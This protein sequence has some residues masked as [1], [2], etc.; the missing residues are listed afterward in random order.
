MRAYQL[1]EILPAEQKIVFLASILLLSSL[2]KVVELPLS[3]PICIYFLRFL[4]YFANE[5]EKLHQRHSRPPACA[6]S[7]RQT[8]IKF[9]VS[10]NSL[11]ERKREASRWWSFL[12][13][14]VRGSCCDD[15]DTGAESKVIVL[16]RLF[17]IFVMELKLNIFCRDLREVKTW[18]F[19]HVARYFHIYSLSPTP[20]LHSFFSIFKSSQLFSLLRKLPSCINTIWHMEEM[21]QVWRKA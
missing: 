16:C 4:F 17:E 2:G 7:R 10:I 14:W 15:S 20:P 18:K 11:T 21:E 19:P 12:T 13:S 1:Q 8:W 9:I 5:N 3:R 6:L